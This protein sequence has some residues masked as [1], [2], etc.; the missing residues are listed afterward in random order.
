MPTLSIFYGIV[1]R[2]YFADHAPPHFHALYG[3]YQAQLDIKTLR[4]IKGSLPRQAKALVLKWARQHQS[5]LLEA[6]E[7]CCKTVQPKQIAP[8]E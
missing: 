3:S 2:M 6:W 1:I 4:V 5:E 7:A 8:L